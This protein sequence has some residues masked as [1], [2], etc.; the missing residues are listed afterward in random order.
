MALGLEPEILLLHAPRV[1]K[2]L[3]GKQEAVT[4]LLV[5]V[6]SVCLATRP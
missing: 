4:Q 3:F 6:A 5:T 2:M 1:L